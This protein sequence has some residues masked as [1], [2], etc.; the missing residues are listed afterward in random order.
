MW[1]N[2]IAIE[3]VA[4]K[5]QHAFAARSRRIDRDLND[6]HPAIAEV[7]REHEET[8]GTAL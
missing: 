2:V 1:L 7:L 3:I 8:H 4:E 6:Y 5:A